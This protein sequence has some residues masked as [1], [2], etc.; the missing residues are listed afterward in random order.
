MA[1]K[2]T[3]QVIERDG[4]RGRTYALRFRAYGERQFLT[5]CLVQAADAF[6]RE[7]EQEAIAV[8]LGLENPV[9]ADRRGLRASEEHR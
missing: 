4:K 1:R 7:L 2:A 8:P 5:L 9:V 6:R 3:G